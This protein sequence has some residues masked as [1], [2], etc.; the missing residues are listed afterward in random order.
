MSRADAVIASLNREGH[1]FT[2]EDIISA[3]N[4]LKG[5]IDKEIKPESRN[6]RRDLLNKQASA[7]LILDTVARA[8]AKKD[9]AV[10]PLADDMD[11]IIA[12]VVVAERLEMGRGQRKHYEKFEQVSRNERTRILEHQFDLD[13]VER[14]LEAAATPETH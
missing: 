9:A 12:E 13:D 10:S 3:A 7:K 14:E 5:N 2:S 8:R 4:V 6:A 1:P 11:A